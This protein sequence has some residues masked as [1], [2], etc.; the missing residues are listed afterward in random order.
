MS[1]QPSC[2]K[3]SAVPMWRSAFYLMLL[4][5]HAVKPVLLVAFMLSLT[6]CAT[7][8]DREDG[9][10][11]G[12]FNRGVWAFND[13]ADKIVVRPVTKAYR[14]VTPRPARRGLSRIFDNLSEPFS[15]INAL[16]QGQPKRAGQS[17]ARFA[18]NST[19]GVGGLADHA[20]GMG[21]KPAPE[22]FGQTLAK[23]GVKSGPYL[24]L[25]FLGPSNFRD[26]T[27]T[28]VGF[29]A[30][31]WRVAVR[32]SDLSSGAQLGITGLDVID[33]R[34]RLIDSG[35]DGALG[36][37]ADSYAMARSAAGQRRLALIENRDEDGAATDATG[38][39][40]DVDLD[41]ALDAAESDAATTTP[42]P[43][44]SETPQPDN[45]LPPSSDA[46]PKP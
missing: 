31:P 22:D 3:A 42:L 21:I 27:G 33:I 15:A 29:L 16:L 45:A 20:T 32:Q 28:G 17:I 36:A 9:D 1:S 7:S 30:D 25:P 37:S 46:S 43:D 11:L 10:P 24:V 39:G 6:G 12:G 34:N 5:K 14:G 19:L 23:W 18:V 8:A 13:N 4:G 44:N 35:A 2:A 41:R 40:S 38:N 26:A